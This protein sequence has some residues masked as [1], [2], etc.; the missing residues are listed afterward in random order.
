[1]AYGTAEGLM[2]LG[3]AAVAITAASAVARTRRSV[4]RTRDERGAAGD[5]FMKRVVKVSLL[6]MII[7][8]GMVWLIDRAEENPTPDTGSETDSPQKQKGKKGN[9]R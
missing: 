9:N 5:G 3:F 6:V 7:A 8:G 1:M 4:A 2:W